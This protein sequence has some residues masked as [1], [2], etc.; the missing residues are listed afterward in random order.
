MIV[1]VCTCRFG[2]RTFQNVAVGSF[3]FDS[4]ENVKT[5]SAFLQRIWYAVSIEKVVEE[6]CSYYNDGIAT[7]RKHRGF[8]EISAYQTRT[9]FF[10][11]TNVCLIWSRT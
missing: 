5:R 6:I 3:S 11:W 10:G 8:S 4:H 9:I 7:I 2:R 1:R